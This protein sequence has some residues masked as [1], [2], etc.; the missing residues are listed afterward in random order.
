MTVFLTYLYIPLSLDRSMS[1]LYRDPDWSTN[2]DAAV[3]RLL[4][5]GIELQ[6]V[7][8]WLDKK[9]K[10]DFFSLSDVWGALT[11]AAIM[12]QVTGQKTY[13]LLLLIFSL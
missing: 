12:R 9:A 4:G 3:S 7:I 1:T 2:V 13:I 8:T 6:E 10:E 11:S 5:P